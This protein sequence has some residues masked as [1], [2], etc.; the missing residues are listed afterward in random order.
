MSVQPF[1]VWHNIMG[2]IRLDAWLVMQLVSQQW[3]HLQFLGLP[4]CCTVPLEIERL[5]KL[6]CPMLTK[7]ILDYL[8]LRDMQEH[9]TLQRATLL[10][11]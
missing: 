9:Y 4:S 8:M 2:C 11:H 3:P 1:I 5:L 10:A 6:R 7:L